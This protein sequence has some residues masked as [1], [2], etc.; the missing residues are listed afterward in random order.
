MDGRNIEPR[1]VLWAVAE[2]SWE[3]PT[4]TPYR[5]PATLEDTSPSG[6]CI[7]VKTP[8]TVGSKLIV[9]WQ[10]EQFSAVARNCRK[11]GRDFLLGVRRDPA[12]P[13]QPAAKEAI[14]RCPQ[15]APP[16]PSSRFPASDAV[17]M[18][19][20]PQA[21]SE[22]QSRSCHSALESRP[23]IS[24]TQLSRIPAAPAAP[25]NRLSAKSTVASTPIPRD[26]AQSQPAGAPPRQE[27][28][29]MQSKGFFPNFW[30]H[31]H[32]QPVAPEN[33][34]TTHGGFYEQ[35]AIPSRGRPDRP[36]N[37]SALLR[38]H[39]PRR[40]HSQ[41]ALRIRHPQSRRHA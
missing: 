40:R 16:A 20:A 18:P 8:I 19:V 37:Q 23:P 33:R 39:L 6:A 5:E 15:S 27:R 36:P 38:R 4:G 14:P 41:P 10:R 2:V 3:D 30:R 9:K 11:D 24:P 35:I 22:R 13:S 26:A 28:N 21:P 31:Q 17:A 34:S 7:R 1:T 25:A 29:V 32:E 12:P